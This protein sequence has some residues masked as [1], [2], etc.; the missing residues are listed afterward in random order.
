M[1]SPIAETEPVAGCELRVA[2]CGTG[3]L[4]LCAHHESLGAPLSSGS[5]PQTVVATDPHPVGMLNLL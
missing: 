2:G 1:T 4:V 5:A 3:G